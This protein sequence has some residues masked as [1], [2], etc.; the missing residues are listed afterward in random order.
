MRTPPLTYFE[1]SP[2]PVLDK[3]AEWV[4][5]ELLQFFIELVFEL[6]FGGV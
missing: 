3:V 4:L 5:L 6:V 2:N 1:E